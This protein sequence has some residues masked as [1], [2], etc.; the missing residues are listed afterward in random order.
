MCPGLLNA[1]AALAMDHRVCEKHTS[2]LK[3][4]HLA[5]IYASQIP[6]SHR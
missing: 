4:A 3:K 1:A 6:N 2:I 5:H